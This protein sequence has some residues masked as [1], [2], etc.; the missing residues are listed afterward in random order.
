MI[1]SEPDR[2]ALAME[3]MFGYTAYFRDNDPRCVADAHM[4]LYGSVTQMCREASAVYTDPTT[5]V[6]TKIGAPLTEAVFRTNHGYDPVIRENYLW[7]QSPNDNSIQR[8]ALAYIRECDVMFSYFLISDAFS[9]YASEGVRVGLLQAVNVTSIVADKG[10]KHP[11]VCMVRQSS[12]VLGVDIV[13]DNTDGSNVLSVVFHPLT[14][15]MYVAWERD[16]GEN[17]RPAW[18]VMG[19]VLMC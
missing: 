14:Q 10:S 6:T 18:C 8:Y 16:S 7:G 17:W 13:Q 5:N 9:E 15:Q 4:L 19:I 2:S 3:T 12:I 1:A 11:Y